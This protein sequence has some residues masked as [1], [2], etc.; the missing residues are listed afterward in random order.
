[1]RASRPER[2]ILYISLDSI[3][4]G[5]GFS[6]VARLVEVLT[7]RGHPYH[8]LSLEPPAALEAHGPALRARLAE[9]GV[10]WTAVAYQG[11]GGGGSA[12]ANLRTMCKTA[13]AIA[14][15]IRPSLVHSRG[16]QAT[17]V[18]YALRRLLGIPY[19][20]DARGYWIDECREEGRWF[21]RPTTYRIG[22][23]LERALFGAA[24]AAVT[25]TAL[26]RDDLVSGTMGPWRGRPAVVVPTVADFESFRLRDHS[27]LPKA[28][29]EHVRRFVDGK[30]VIGI[31]GSLNRSYRV[32]DTL[33]LVRRVLQRC[34]DSRLVVL[35]S[36][37]EAWTSA[38]E[39]AAVPLNRTLVCSAPNDE[40]PLW[41]SIL[42]WGCL[43]LRSPFAKRGSM[44]TKLAEFAAVG[45]RPIHHGCNEEVGR[46]VDTLGTGFQL[47]DTSKPR[48]DEIATTVAASPHLSVARLAEGRQRLRPHFG[49]EHGADRYHELLSRLVMPQRR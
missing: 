27:C 32:E 42:D 5:L 26:Q 44:P 46:W 18:A 3:L 36:Q 48:L 31:V 28:L 15:R 29:P 47:P 12:T 45:V 37:T 16:Y 13:L 41:L 6:Q 38:V 1:M 14:R 25:L 33:Y 9:R 24:S 2:P 17:L 7:T 20:F 19:L 49:L 35:S 40:M 23:R 8:I 4:G 22:K 39:E 21:H 43:L 11:T 10:G 30:R 34:A